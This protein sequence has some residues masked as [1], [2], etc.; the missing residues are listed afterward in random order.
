MSLVI[1]LVFITLIVCLITRILPVYI[2]G[3]KNEL[4]HTYTRLSEEIT[5]F[6]YGCAVLSYLGD[7]FVNFDFLVN[8]N[9]DKNI[10]VNYHEKANS[11]E[12][13]LIWNMWYFF[14]LLL[15]TF[16]P[17]LRWGDIVENILHHMSTVC[18]MGAAFYGSW[19]IISVWVILIN[20]IFDVFFSLS[21]IAYKLGHWSQTPLF[22]IALVLH[23]LLRVCFFP[24]RII[25]LALVTKH[26]N[27]YMILYPPF[28]MTIPLWCLYVYWMVRM[29]QIS[30]N[31]LC[32]GVQN[33]DYSDGNHSPHIKTT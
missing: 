1:E 20:V 4:S 15:V 10:G 23:V 7:S 17:P 28:F 12:P 16:W 29:L 27:T 18:L 3:V 14:M 32:K 9:I 19:L 11:V 26:V 25:K 33:V 31:R 5:I 21:R 13:F 6:L 8:E 22:G 30:Y 24:Y 2:L